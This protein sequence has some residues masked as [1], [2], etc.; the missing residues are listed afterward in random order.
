M[1]PLRSPTFILTAFHPI[2]VF[3]LALTIIFFMATASE[4]EKIKSNPI[5]EGLDPF[6]RFFELTRVDLDITK[7]SDVVQ[8]VLS[9]A[10]TTGNAPFAWYVAC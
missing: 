1:T 4:L 3:H 6:R 7:S 10:V 8:A 5:K 2:H 9:T